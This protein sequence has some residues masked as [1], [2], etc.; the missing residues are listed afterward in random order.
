MA[1]AGL[2]DVLLVVVVVAAAALGLSHVSA[3]EVHTAQEL[4]VKNGTVARLRC[5]FTSWEVI[6]SAASVTWSFQAQGASSAV[7]FFYYSNGM[8][9]PGQHVPFKDKISW[10]GDL[11]KKD[12]SISIADI[13]FLD[14][15]T[16]VCDV[17][18]PPDIV[19][20]PG[21]IR[22]EVLEREVSGQEQETDVPPTQTD[23]TEERVFVIL[24][25]IK[26]LVN[27]KFKSLNNRLD[28]FESKLDEVRRT[29]IT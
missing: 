8:A 16:Y 28:D 1:S 24:Q 26:D 5:T 15:G 12:A 14:S 19:V 22:L 25:E 7:S 3:V 18:N 20:T 2:L 13:Q 10:A 9:Y 6:S 23:S 21:E 17:K 11:S 4:R 29:L 27:T